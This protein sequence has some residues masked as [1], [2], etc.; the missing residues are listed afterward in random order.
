MITVFG[1]GFSAAVTD[2]TPARY[3]DL[4]LVTIIPGNYEHHEND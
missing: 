3:E 2:M 4:S 1:H